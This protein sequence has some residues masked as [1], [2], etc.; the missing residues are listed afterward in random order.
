MKSVPSSLEEV[1]REFHRIR[2]QG[3]KRFPKELWQAAF[4]LAATHSVA[5][6]ASALGI[7]SQYFRLRLAQRKENVQ[8]FAQVHPLPSES[9][10]FVEITLKQQA[11]PLTLRWTGPIKDLPVLICR[12]FR[13]EFT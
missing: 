13:G 1:A 8:G 9:H 7:S 3:H 6:I 10:S 2:S 5:E 12:L 4:K 11:G